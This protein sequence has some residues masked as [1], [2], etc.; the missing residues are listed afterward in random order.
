M[1]WN[2]MRWDGMRWGGMEISV[3]MCIVQIKLSNDNLL[4]SLEIKKTEH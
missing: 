4:N 1:G 2:G 3:S